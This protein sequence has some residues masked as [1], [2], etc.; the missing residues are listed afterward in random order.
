M[1]ARS[2]RM[3]NLGA[4]ERG[5]TKWRHEEKPTPMLIFPAKYHFFRQT[6]EIHQKQQQTRNQIT[7]HGQNT[8]LDKLQRKIIG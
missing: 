7:K 1:T 8:N 4:A 2:G 3:T 5:T 6:F